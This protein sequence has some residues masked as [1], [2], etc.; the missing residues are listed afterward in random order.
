MATSPS[1]FAERHGVPRWYD[2]GD[3]LM[4]D[5]DVDVVY[6]STPLTRTRSTP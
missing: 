3:A 1:D 2:D 4:A 5:P 6:I